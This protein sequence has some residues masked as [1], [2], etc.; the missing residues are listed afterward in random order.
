MLMRAFGRRSV[1]WFSSSAS[2]KDEIAELISGDIKEYPVMVYMKGTPESPQ[3][4]FS[5][6]AVQILQTGKKK[7]RDEK[8]N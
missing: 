6:R 4:G 3:C 2:A 5:K 1:R 7:E 8:K